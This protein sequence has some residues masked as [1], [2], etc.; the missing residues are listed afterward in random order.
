[1]SAL[2]L[3]VSFAVSFGLIKALISSRLEGMCAVFMKS[4]PCETNPM[5][6]AMTPVL[7][8]FDRTIVGVRACARNVCCDVKFRKEDE[9]AY[10]LSMVVEVAMIGRL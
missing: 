5:R 7:V 9:V 6:T 8:L 2:S 10:P 3:A 1:M 4:V